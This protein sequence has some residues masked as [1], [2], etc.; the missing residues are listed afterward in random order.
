VPPAQT[1]R[2]PT[3]PGVLGGAGG[4]GCSPPL[5]AAS[6]AE[7]MHDVIRK[8]K[9]KGEWKVSARP[10]GA[11]RGGGGWGGGSREGGQC[12]QGAPKGGE[13]EGKGSS[14]AAR[15]APRSQPLSPGA[16]GG[17]AQHAHALLL[18]QDDRHHDGGHNE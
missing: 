11:R 15:R 16:G 8:V 2:L 6:L 10:R 13:G 12:G 14:P 4:L 3:G 5:R 9:K 17:P 7:I 1:P 18:L